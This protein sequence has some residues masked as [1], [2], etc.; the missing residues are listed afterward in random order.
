MKFKVEMIRV[1]RLGKLNE[2]D[3]DTWLGWSLNQ[4]EYLPNF[5][6]AT[7]SNPSGDSGHSHAAALPAPVPQRLGISS[8]V[9]R[10]GTVETLLSTYKPLTTKESRC[11]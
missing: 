7:E 1:G 11:P 2:P 5:K 6:S 10:E 3:T 4:P 9:P 8:D